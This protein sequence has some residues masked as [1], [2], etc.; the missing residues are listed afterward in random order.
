[1]T[2][3]DNLQGFFRDYCNGE[4]DA[5]LSGVRRILIYRDVTTPRQVKKLINTYVSYV[6]LSRERENA[7]KVRAGF[8]NDGIDIIAKISVLQADFNDVYDLMFEEDD[9]LERILNTY[10]D[11]TSSRRD[12]AVD[13]DAADSVEGDDEE[14]NAVD[15]SAVTVA[16]EEKLNAILNRLSDRVKNAARITGTTNPFRQAMPLINFLQHTRSVESDDILSYLYV[17][18]DKITIATGTKNRRDF[19]NAALS[20]NVEEAKS[21]LTENPSLAE[22]AHVFIQESNDSE[23]IMALISVLT[24]CAGILSDESKKIVADD[25]AVSSENISNEC[26]E[27]DLTIIDFNVLFEFYDL[28]ERKSQFEDLLVFILDNVSYKRTAEVARAF[29]S[30]YDPLPAKVRESLA[31]F[32]LVSITKKTIDVDKFIDIRK[33]YISFDDLYTQKWIEKYYRYLISSI[34]A[35]EDEEELETYIDE[36]KAVFY[37]LPKDQ[38]QD[39]LR[40]LQPLYGLPVMADTLIE[41]MKGS[42]EKVAQETVDQVITDQISNAE[43]DSANQ[44]LKQFKYSVND[45]NKAVIDIYLE[46]QAKS[47]DMAAMLKNVIRSG[48][49]TF[50][51]L[52]KTI[53]KIINGA[54]S[55]GDANQVSTVCELIKIKD[56]S[57]AGRISIL[58]KPATVANKPNYNGITEILAVQ[59]TVNPQFVYEVLKTNKDYINNNFNSTN[60]SD[61]FLFFNTDIISQTIDVNHKAEGEISD[62]ER[63]LVNTYFDALIK[64]FDANRLR[65]EVI[66]SFLVLDD[67]IT[68]GRIKTIE[69]KFF[70]AKNNENVADLFGIYNSHYSVLYNIESSRNH[71]VDVALMFLPIST[72]KNSVLRS[73][74][75]WFSWISET[76]QLAKI[77][78]ESNDIRDEVSLPLLNEFLTNLIKD[79]GSEGD[80]YCS[81]VARDTSPDFMNKIFKGGTDELKHVLEDILK[82]PGNYD[83]NLILAMIRW[84][85]TCY[86][87]KSVV[88]YAADIYTVAVETIE[89]EEE[90]GKIVNSL[91]DIPR[92]V[93]DRNKE[94]WPG[95]Y[96]YLFRHT[97][98]EELKKR[99]LSIAADNKLI[100]RT[101]KDLPHLYADEAKKL[102]K[103]SKE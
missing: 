13:K 9:M 65:N 79:K 16:N 61:K 84:M 35:T 41:F 28:T 71:F 18:E 64:V 80:K 97:N 3:T 88:P 24:R 59:Y 38:Y 92:R 20:G 26:N 42:E 49:D 100:M 1:M 77:I 30:H 58:V 66:H 76:P 11:W 32:T 69:P 56:T 93:I 95:V 36:L 74:D 46:T 91:E 90:R 52:P 57:A 27:S 37:E 31:T 96:T 68:D 98:S 103:E 70:G 81:M 63:S 14:T 72:E 99:I 89:K 12:I 34:E 102:R 21:L 82:N 83:A 10:E 5:F 55:T 15:N 17:A 25:I 67:L 51:Y 87:D 45:K 4:S 22:A 29:Y 85:N 47:V 53:D 44:F 43:E 50:K 62:D 94:K 7:G 75:R 78:Y 33:E 48:A 60:V 19:I 2:F 40:K 73:M 101:I 86:F 8:T 39:N 6:M 23:D 54:I